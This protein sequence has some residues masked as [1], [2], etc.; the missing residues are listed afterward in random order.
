MPNDDA[1]VERLLF[2]LLEHDYP[3]WRITRFERG[4][5]AARLQPPTE[6]QKAEGI[7]G[8]ITHHSIQQLRE[9][10]G[11]QLLIEQ[12]Y[13]CPRTD[14]ALYAV[15][16]QAAAGEPVKECCLEAA[17]TWA[18]N[19]LTQLLDVTLID[20]HTIERVPLADYRD[21]QLRRAYLAAGGQRWR[22]FPSH[23]A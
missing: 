19:V 16:E 17:L 5:T 10:L 1:D 12:G 9:A 2:T 11:D 15:L 4:Y 7:V 22:P 20:E 21:W 6:Q 8:A 3:A 14:N 23:P 13:H 18:W